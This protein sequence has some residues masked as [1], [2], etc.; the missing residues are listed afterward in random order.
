MQLQ[1]NERLWS[2]TDQFNLAV[3]LPPQGHPPR[4]LDQFLS[5]QAALLQRLVEESD[6]ADLALA[7]LR[8][9]ESLPLEFRAGLPSRLLDDPRT[10][11]M[12]FNAL[13]PLNSQLAA[14]K[15]QA[16]SALANPNSPPN[17]KDLREYAEELDLER[18][19]ERVI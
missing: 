13:A 5:L 10:P 4:D 8:L 3:A 2:P 12:L 15:E 17:Q 7:N 16:R 11:A 1:N 14:Y 6:P 9:E 19:L 18:F